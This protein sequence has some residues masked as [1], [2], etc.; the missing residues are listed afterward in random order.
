MGSIDLTVELDQKSQDHQSLQKPEMPVLNWMVIH[1]TVT[2]FT[3]DHKSEP[4]GGAR[5]KVRGFIKV[6]AIGVVVYFSLNQSG[7]ATPLVK[8]NLTD[9]TEYFDLFRPAIE[10]KSLFGW[11]LTT[12]VHTKT[13]TF[14]VGHT[15]TLLHFGK[16]QD[17]LSVGKHTIPRIWSLQ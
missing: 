6:T 12:H 2:D 17:N 4:H 10:T 15:K 7:R 16:S 11:L 13:I 3:L 5:G 9:F 14:D 8:L 1:P